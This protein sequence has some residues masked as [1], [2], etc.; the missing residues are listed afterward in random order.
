MPTSLTLT[1]SQL[2]AWSVCLDRRT[3][4]GSAVYSYCI[5]VTRGDIKTTFSIE[6]TIGDV[7]SA[8]HS[9]IALCLTSGDGGP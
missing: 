1:R 6:S 7:F 4:T 5:K 8:I 2:S 9:N 3:Q